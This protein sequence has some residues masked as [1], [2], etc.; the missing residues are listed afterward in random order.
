[1]KSSARM[2]VAAI[3]L[4]VITACSGLPRGLNDTEKI[5]LEGVDISVNFYCK[6]KTYRNKVVILVTNATETPAT[7]HFVV[8]AR[9]GENE[10]PD[11]TTEPETLAKDELTTIGRS[12]KAGTTFSI[13]VYGG[14][15]HIATSELG[16]E[17]ACKE[18]DVPTV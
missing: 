7:I 16:P 18:N 11:G 2:A 4:L 1:M 6:E 17:D 12:T 8:T 9:T 5:S 13:E 10:A 15:T 3:L 14:G